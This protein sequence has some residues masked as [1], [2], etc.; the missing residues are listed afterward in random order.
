MAVQGIDAVDN[1]RQV[2]D[3]VDRPKY[4]GKEEAGS[5]IVCKEEGECC[6]REIEDGGGAQENGSVGGVEG[7]GPGQEFAEGLGGGGW[8]CVHWG[9]GRFLGGG[10]LRFCLLVSGML[11]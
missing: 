9:G 10:G 5:E 7:D 8:G 11:I 6:G 3:A 1:E 4:Q 2:Y